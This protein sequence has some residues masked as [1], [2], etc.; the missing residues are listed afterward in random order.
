MTIIDASIQINKPVDVVF[1]FISNPANNKVLTAGITDVIINGPIAVGT[2]FT[3]KG[4]AYGRV[5]STENEIV[6]FEPNKF[7][8]VK[9]LAAPPATDV[10]NTS[11]FETVDGGTKL[12]VSM[13]V[14]IFPGTEGMVMPQLKN[15]LAGT[16]AT[17]KQLIEG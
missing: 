1:G 2:R 10:T 11:K 13:D 5:Y 12:T 4:Q 8:A 6:A 7:Y 16:A 15:M 17:Y 9:T 14:S 3:I